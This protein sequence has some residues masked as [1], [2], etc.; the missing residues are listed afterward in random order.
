MN[1]MI[2]RILSVSKY[3]FLIILLIF[4]VYPVYWMFFAGTFNSSELPNFLFSLTPGNNTAANYEV[5]Q[6]SFSVPIVLWNTFFVAIVG[7]IFGVI[8]NVFMG[9]ALAMYDFR[10][11]NTIFLIFLST[12]F[13]GG[14][15]AMIPSF[16]II[17]GMNL[18]NTLWAIILP[19]I[20]STYTAFLAKQ[21]LMDF[22][23][24]I[25]QSGRIDGCGEIKMF[26]KLVLPNNLAM[27]S[28][29]A[30]ITF[31]TFWNGYLWNLIVTSSVDKYTLQVALA[32]IYP[33]AAIWTYAPIKML[34]ATISI[35]PILIIFVSMQKY[36]INSIAGAVKG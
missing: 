28:T 19:G 27:I 17:M 8:V 12:M 16:E 7:T 33:E 3:L 24:E 23:M 25:L 26:F 5:I 18:Y 11:K 6:Q 29:I 20:Y 14:T 36:F 2:N 32:S 34:G 13:L 22:P 31:M 9:Y 10:F 21:T 30:L 35:V 15:A 1:K 4:T